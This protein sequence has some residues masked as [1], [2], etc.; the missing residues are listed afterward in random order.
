MVKINGEPITGNV[1]AEPVGAYHLPPVEGAASEDIEEFSILSE[2]AAAPGTFRKMPAGGN[3]S[4]AG[5][6]PRKTVLEEGGTDGLWV[7]YDSM[8]RVVSGVYPA[9]ITKS[10]VT[11]AS[12]VMTAGELLEASSNVAGALQLGSTTPLARLVDR[13]EFE[14]G[15]PQWSVAVCRVVIP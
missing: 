14:V 10:A 1:N 15:D 7:E 12:Q 9:R 13:I 6:A 5:I 8:G 4:F 3:P 11:G 2:V